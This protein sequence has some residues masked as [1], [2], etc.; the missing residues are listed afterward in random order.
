MPSL[1][2]VFQYAEAAAIQGQ[3]GIGNPQSAAA[4]AATSA[5]SFQTDT[6]S[7]WIVDCMMGTSADRFFGMEMGSFNL[8]SNRSPS[9]RARAAASARAR[10]VH[11]I[12]PPPNSSA[13]PSP[14]TR[15]PGAAQFRATTERST[16]AGPGRRGQSFRFGLRGRCRGR[17]AHCLV[18]SAIS[19]AHI[20]LNGLCEGV[21]HACDDRAAESRRCDFQAEAPSGPRNS[22]TPA[23]LV[24]VSP[25]SAP[26][27]SKAL[28]LAPA[29][30]APPG[31]GDGAGQR[32]PP[33]ISGFV[34]QARG[35]S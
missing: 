13:R 28:T 16:P 18:G 15:P 2:K 24:E 34:V 17:Y 6:F 7:A 1:A 8:Y 32:A 31:I 35:V 10:L 26:P 20:L 27:E 3:A 21:G 23:A 14:E 4:A 25:A 22:Y 33:G 29:T 12:E 11:V 5:S 19:Q 9:S 30:T